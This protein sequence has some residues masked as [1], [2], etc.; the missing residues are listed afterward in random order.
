MASD[1][2]QE[3]MEICGALRRQLAKRIEGDGSISAGDFKVLIDCTDSMMWNEIRAQTFD[4][5]TEARKA[6]LE[7]EASYGG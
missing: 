1:E 6:E 7:R 5:T 3:W 2:Q 4:E